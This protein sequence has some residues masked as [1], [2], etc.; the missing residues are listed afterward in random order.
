MR[1]GQPD[2]VTD[3]IEKNLDG[4]KVVRVGFVGS[5]SW[6]SAYKYDTEGGPSYFIKTALGQDEG[7]FQGEALGLQAMYETHTLRIPKVFHY[8]S[9]STVPAGR[10]LG[11]GGSF[12]VME[13]L[14]LG[15]RARQDELGR[16]LALMHSAPPSDENAKAGKFGFAVDNTIGGTPQ[17]NGWMD[18]WVDFFRERRLLHQLRLAGDPQLTELGRRLADNLEVFFE[19]VQVKPCLL[20]GDL[21]SGNMTGVAEGGWAILDPATYY[22]HSEAE[23]GMSWCA[24]F[25]RKFWDAYFEVLPPA[26]GNSFVPFLPRSPRPRHLPPCTFAGMWVRHCA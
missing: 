23:F 21:W 7:M 20:H 18:N 13:C 6:S 15:G 25:D 26:P 11:G 22:G 12:I 19:G 4:G 9:L 24:G 1:A 10:G 3:W 14:N 17:P 8:G 5:S 16:G 2:V